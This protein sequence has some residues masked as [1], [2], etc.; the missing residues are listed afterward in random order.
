VTVMV[1]GEEVPHDPDEYDGWSYHD[2]T[3]T[4]YLWGAYLPE[5]GSTVEIYYWTHG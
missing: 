3:N 4:I 5:R 2:D 1:D